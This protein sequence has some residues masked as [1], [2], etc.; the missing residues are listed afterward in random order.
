[1]PFKSSVY[2]LTSRLLHFSASE[3]G[4]LS[5]PATTVEVPLSPLD[6]EVALNY[7]HSAELELS[8][9]PLPHTLPG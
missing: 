7:T 4:L 5:S 3:S 6:Y 8:Y 2:S 9:K 1:M